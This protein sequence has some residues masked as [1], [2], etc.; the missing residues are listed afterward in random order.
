MS[1]DSSSRPSG[2]PPSQRTSERIERGSSESPQ[3]LDFDRDPSIRRVLNAPMPL[4]PVLVLLTEPSMFICFGGGP[5]VITGLGD[6]DGDNCADFAVGQ[7][8]RTDKSKSSETWICSG[9]D[10]RVLLRIPGQRVCEGFGLSVARAADLDGDGKRD[11]AVSAPGAGRYPYAR[12]CDD[13]IEGLV[14]IHSTHDAALL[15]TIESPNAG[16]ADLFG[17]ELADAG[18][19]DGDGASDLLVGA[20]RVNRAFLYSGK[21]GGLLRTLVPMRN[22]GDFGWSVCGGADLDG[23][24]TPDMAIGAPNWRPQGFVE[25]FSGRDGAR[26]S[27]LEGNTGR[28]AYGA[29][30]GSSLAMLA[31]VDGDQRVELLVG[32]DTESDGH[33]RAF[34]GTTRTSSFDL[35]NPD[36]FG[37]F[38]TSV[39]A[40]GDLDRDGVADF[41]VGDADNTIDDE[42]PHGQ[43]CG[44]VSAFSGKTR[45]RL[46]VVFGDEQFDV[47]GHCVACVGDVNAD[48]VDDIVAESSR[49]YRAISGKDGKVLYDVKRDASA[50]PMATPSKGAK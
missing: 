4:L 14:R 24:G 44:G 20:P 23:D 36:L 37:R 42:M 27:A 7:C 26:L 34:S 32:S 11:L 25:V 15:R 6:L 39:A 30:F 31:D 40:C 1:A 43:A 9:K 33:V 50:P 41:V 3:R 18:D 8:H 16:K 5:R 13:H 19:C 22:D 12:G 47:L 46:F 45:K 29:R 49:L 17:W 38:G 21:S 35:A 10:G 48:G 28:S 2:A